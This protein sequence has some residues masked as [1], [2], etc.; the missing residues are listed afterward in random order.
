MSTL[1]VTA[2]APALGQVAAAPTKEAADLFNEGT[3]L[4][5]QNHPAEA[6]EKFRKATTISPNFAEAHGNLGTALVIQ[7]NAQSALPEL[8]L[9]VKMKP[10]VAPA[11]ATL[12]SCYQAVGRT[13]EAVTAFHKYLELDPNG[14]LAPKVRSLS[15]TLESELKRSG[16]VDDLGKKD[17]LQEAVYGGLARWTSPTIKVY[18]K[19]GDKVPG[20][21]PEYIDYL[22]QAFGEWEK[23]AN[24]KVH[25]VFVDQQAGAQITCSW[26]NR[27]DE[28]VST[29]EGGH[30]VLAPDGHGG[31]VN[32]TMTLLTVPLQGQELNTDF[33]RCADLHEVGHALGIMGHSKDPKDIMFTSIAFGS[34]PVLTQRDISTV[35]A[36]YSPEAVK[37]AGQSID[38]SKLVT[39]DP[40]TRLNRVI[41]LNN[42]AKV[43][44]DK[45][46]ALGAVQKMEAAHELDPNN[47]LICTNLGSAYGQ[48]ASMFMIV[49][50]FDQAEGYYKKAIPLLEH[51]TN[52][53]NLSPVLQ[54]YS[55]LLRMTNRAPE[56]A[57]IDA[58]VKSL[59][60]S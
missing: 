58:Q 23:N 55:K 3:A 14:V 51:G 18:I 34:K 17:Y 22:K 10:T 37:M 41:S 49:R 5:N 4:L 1:L 29:A 27:T 47:A 21:R 30:T 26:T 54:N 33:A 48:M 2:F 50:K 56:A 25:F 52:N 57:K 20:F 46:D 11:W 38:V 32:A 15:A 9:A 8:E 39:G 36:L 45:G 28:G 16:G 6:A 53:I 40:T 19:P 35:Q 60:G 43:L 59:G 7:G 31:I 24:G 44:L 42:E 12:G 13:K